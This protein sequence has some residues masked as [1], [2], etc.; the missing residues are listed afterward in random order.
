MGRTSARRWGRLGAAVVLGGLMSF[1]AAGVA[2]AADSTTTPVK[3][4]AGV[5]GD[6]FML[7]DK[8]DNHADAALITLAIAGGKPVQAYCIDLNNPLKEGGTYQETAWQAS[9]VANLEK[10]QW[11]LVNSFPKVDAATVL[12][13]AGAG[14]VNGGERDVLVY[15]ATQGAIWHFSDGFELGDHPGGDYGVVKKVYG[16]LVD[17]AEKAQGVKEPAPTLS[18]NPT[19]ATGEI[20]SKLGP[21]TVT[22]PAEKAALKATGGK[23]VDAN[24]AEVTGPVADGGKFWLT[25]DQAGKVTVDATA[26]G[27]VPTGRVFTFPQPAG[28]SAKSVKNF[29]KIILAGEAKAEL[30]AHATGTFTPKAAPVPTL[31]VTGASAVGAAVG[32]V[33]LL[34]GGSLLVVALRRRRVKF[35]A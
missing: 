9:E 16:Y 4:V 34:G 8:N 26:T 32:G 23:V 10:V 3:G 33:A 22:S 24:G 18:I 35:T 20:G 6:G 28:T 19:N 12:Q 14:S 15:A 27:T 17:A 5:A 1:T 25:S 31:P 29:Q 21:Y 7:Y 2:A 11:I 30:V 13:K